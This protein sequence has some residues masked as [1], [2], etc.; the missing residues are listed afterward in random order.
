M[1]IGLA[2][3]VGGGSHGRILRRREDPSH[4]AEA[5]LRVDEVRDARQ[6]ARRAVAELVLRNPVLAGEPGVEH[7]V[8]DVPRHFLRANQHA[9]D[10]GVVH[11]REV[12]PRADV[13]REAG[14]GEELHRRVLQRAFRDAEF[15]FHV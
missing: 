7:A 2:A 5:L 1:A 15:E 3:H 13:E 6:D 8:G 11:G 14:A 10:L 12:R 9:F 4:L